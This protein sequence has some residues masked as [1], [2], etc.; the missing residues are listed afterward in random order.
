MQSAEF[1]RELPARIIAE[2]SLDVDA[3]SGVTYTSK[4]LIKAVQDA[5][6]N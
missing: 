5:L 6:E 4:A 3:V 1:F 2:Q